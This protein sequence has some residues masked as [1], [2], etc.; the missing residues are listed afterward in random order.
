LHDCSIL[1][2]KKQNLGVDLEVNVIAFF[3]SSV[4]TGQLQE[5]KN[6]SSLVAA[7]N[8]NR[9]PDIKKLADILVK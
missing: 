1:L 8:S 3:D 4:D 2:Q 9:K 6:T 5:L 7:S